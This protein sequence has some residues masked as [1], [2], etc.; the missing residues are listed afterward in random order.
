MY[1]VSLTDLIARVRTYTDT[2]NAPTPTDAEITSQINTAIRSVYA[3]LCEG[4]AE[5]LCTSAVIDFPADEGGTGALPND[6]WKLRALTWVRGQYDNVPIYPFASRDRAALMNARYSSTGR[7]RYRLVGGG[8]AG[9]ARYELLP[10]PP[11]TEPPLPI[12]VDYIPDPPVLSGGAPTLYCLAGLDEWVVLEVSIGVMM[13]E[14]SDVSVFMAKR[15]AAMTQ[16]TKS[17]ALRDENRNQVISDVES[18]VD[19]WY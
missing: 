7:L 8:L 16:V 15:Q 17:I 12:R 10:R 3:E 4:G 19:G 6:F 18:D 13:A 14:E 11:D 2:V 9:G 1:N 5:I